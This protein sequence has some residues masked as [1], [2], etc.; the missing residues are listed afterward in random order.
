MDLQQQTQTRKREA[1]LVTSHTL[2]WGMAVRKCRNVLQWDI[3]AIQYPQCQVQRSQDEPGTEGEVVQ[4]DTRFCKGIWGHGW[5]HIACKP[6]TTTVLSAVVPRSTFSQSLLG[7][8]G[9]T[10]EHKTHMIILWQKSRREDASKACPTASK[11]PSQCRRQS[12]TH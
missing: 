2:T 11:R 5:D 3:F 12:T 8:C 6:P 1:G 4:G 10:R 7:T 9:K